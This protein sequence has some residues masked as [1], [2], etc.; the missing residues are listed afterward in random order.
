MN[1]QWRKNLLSQTRDFIVWSIFKC[2]EKSLENSFR[3]RHWLCG[4]AFAGRFD[5]FQSISSH[6]WMWKKVVNGCE[7]HDTKLNT[8]RIL[9][10][11]HS[12]EIFVVGVTLEFHKYILGRS[13][14]WMERDRIIMN[15]NLNILFSFLNHKFSCMKCSVNVIDLS[16]TFE[17]VFN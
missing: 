6:E 7:I 8:W 14:M 5:H 13:L 4:L 3:D 1:F 17:W 9:R 11:K 16:S 12:L 10:S 15:F 2:V